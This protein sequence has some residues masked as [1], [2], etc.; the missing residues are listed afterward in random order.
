MKEIFAKYRRHPRIL[1]LKFITLHS[2]FVGEYG[3][4]KTASLFKEF[5]EVGRSNW[6]LISGIIN[7]KEAITNLNIRD[8][9]R[10][11]QEVTFMG[12]CYGENRIV[13]GRRYLGLSRRMMYEYKGNALEPQTFATQDWLSGL[14]YTVVVAGVD[15][16]KL[17]IE[18]FLEFILN[19][20]KV[21]GYVPLA[22]TRV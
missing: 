20:G 14:D 18:R 12:A 10:Y 5:C 16:Y 3:A 9:M 13:T 11:R 15:A 21:I 1:E 22:E 7:R 6:T 17:E 4:E 8:K 19:L 2:L